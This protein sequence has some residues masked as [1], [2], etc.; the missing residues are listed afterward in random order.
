VAAEQA[1]SS[2]ETVSSAVRMVLLRRAVEDKQ[3]G[4]IELSLRKQ[5]YPTG[6]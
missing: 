3:V 4:N 2:R 5:K 6:K 1:A